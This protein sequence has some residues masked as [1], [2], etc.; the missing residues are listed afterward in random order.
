MKITSVQVKL[1]KK[2]RFDSARSENVKHTKI[3]PYLSIV[4]SIEGSY[5]ISIDNGAPQQTGDGGFF[6]APSNVQQTIVHHVN[7]K[8]GKM[9]CRWIFMDVEVNKAFPL[10]SLYQF[11]T[12]INDDRKTE[13][14]ALFDRLF[15]TDSIWKN[16]SDCYA[17]ID[18]LLQSATPIPSTMHEGVLRAIE[19][20]ADHHREAI[21]IKE[22]ATIANMS[23]SN[24]YAVFKKHKGVSPIAF[25]NNYRLSVAA[26]KLTDTSLTVGEIGYSVGINDSLYFSKLFKK[27]YG[28]SPKEYRAVYKTKN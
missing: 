3:L 20:I 14:N 12:V 8:S 25:L 27:T 10:D 19:H 5:D 21:S 23:E 24:F 22:L 9:S 16:H 17:L 11:P 15:D 6:L 28:I 4:Q 2:G 13:I 26:E 18:C 1:L 7:Q